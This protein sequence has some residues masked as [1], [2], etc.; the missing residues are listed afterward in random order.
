[1][2]SRLLLGLCT[3]L[4][5]CGCASLGLNTGA[6]T[7]ELTAGM[8]RAQVE[9]LLGEPSSVEGTAEGTVATYRLHRYNV[10]W[11][12]FETV[13]DGSGS[14]IAWRMDE[15]GYQEEQRRLGVLTQAFAEGTGGVAGDPGPTDPQLAQW[16]AGEYF[17][18]SSAGPTGGGTTTYLMLCPSGQFML[19][20]ESSYGGDL[21]GGGNWISAA[22]GTDRGRWSVTGNQQGGKIT[23]AYERGDTFT[24]DW[25][26]CGQGCFRFGSLEVGYKGPPTC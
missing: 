3:L 14:L 23:T 13:F 6:R 20:Q 18:F 22:E 11:Y 4:L 26:A 2:S 10:G 1:M 12:P 8:T 9:A 24:N 17:G 16:L 19:R 15:E 5:L 21:S 7:D 25:H